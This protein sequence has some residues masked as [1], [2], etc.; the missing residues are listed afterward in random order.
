M[1]KAHVGH[2]FQKD[3]GYTVPQAHPCTCFPYVM[4]Q[5][6][7]R[8]KTVG[9]PLLLQDVQHLEGM[10]LFGSRHRPKQGNLSIAQIRLENP[11]LNRALGPELA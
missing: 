10:M 6:G 9:M 8:H 3:L 5:C 4:Q 7:L 2:C 1:K 11:V